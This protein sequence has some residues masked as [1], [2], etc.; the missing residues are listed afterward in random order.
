MRSVWVV[1]LSWAFAQFVFTPLQWPVAGFPNAW[2]GGWNAPQFSRIDLDGDGQEELFVFDRTDNSLQIFRWVAGSW[3]YLP[4]ADTLF[5]TRHLSA[6]VLLRDA[7]GD[8]DKDLFTNRNSNVRVFRN[9]APSGT[10]PLWSAWYDTLRSSYY[11]YVTPLYASSTDIPGLVDVDS[12]GD[13]DVLVYEVLGTLIE[14]HRNQAQELYGRPDTLVL[15]LQSACWGHVFENYDY[16]TN[17]FSFQPYFCGPGQRLEG[18]PPLGRTYH[19][20]GTLLVTDLDGNGLKDLIVGD[21]GPP[22][23]IAGFNEGTLDS[24]H[25]PTS[26][27]IAPYPPANPVYL[28]SFPAA[29]YED[30]TGDGKPDLIVANNDPL[31]GEDSRS[32]WMYENLGRVDSP[33]WAMPQI[34]WLHTTQLDVG[35]AAH[36]TL[37]DLNRDGFLDLI[38]SCESYYT[39]SGPKARAFL[40]WGGPSGLSLAD[41][42]WLSL[43]S[44]SLRNPVFAVGDLDNDGRTDLLAGTS[45]GAF[46]HWE[47][48]AAGAADFSLVTQNFA[49]L[50]GPPY[51]APLLYDYDGDGDLDLIVGG[52][53]GRLSLYR[54]DAGGA[55]TLVTDFLGQIEVRDTVSTLLGFARPALI[56]LDTNGVPELLVGNLTGFLRVYLPQWSQPTASWTLVGDLSQGGLGIRRASPTTWLTPDSVVILIGTQRGGVQPFRIEYG[57]SPTALLTSAESAFPLRLRSGQGLLEVE[58]EAEGYLLLYSSLGQLVHQ[59]PLS[60]GQ[61]LTLSL[62]A[63]VYA[64]SFW[65]SQGGVA[66]RVRVW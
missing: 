21:N 6:W 42:D 22:Y 52:R 9:L 47:E 26:T 51:A 64:V 50:S 5:P 18:E 15:Q 53:N 36:P 7:D 29:Y 1:G 60:K 54:Q 40:L 34:G 24:A 57:G 46:W 2:T 59:Q 61:Q 55:F 32:V 49:G 31:A 48:T 66:R 16:Q 63:G 44:Y 65:G 56:D 27:A 8:G 38:L 12:D 35:T 33:S 14:W 23:L 28:P 39:P 62:P 20:G 10:A 58:A 13:L 4:Q 3:Q 19:S 37:A 11:N 41:T 17:V 45:T 30:V 43:S 25:I